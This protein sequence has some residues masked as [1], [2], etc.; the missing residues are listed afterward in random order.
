MKKYNNPNKQPIKASDSHEPVLCAFIWCHGNKDFSIWETDAISDSDLNRLENILSKYTN[1]GT[2][3][4][5]VYDDIAEY[6]N[7][8]YTGGIDD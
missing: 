5:N 6:V 7:E 1:E 8:D 4:R 2:S 3:A